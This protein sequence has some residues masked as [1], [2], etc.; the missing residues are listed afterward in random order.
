MRRLEMSPGRSSALLRVRNIDD[1]RDFEEG[2]RLLLQAS[3]KIKLDRAKAVLR[4][5]S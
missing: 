4:G 2:E 1:F 3:E 5:A